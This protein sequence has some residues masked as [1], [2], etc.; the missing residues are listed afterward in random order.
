MIRD[1]D[2]TPTRTFA[3]YDFVFSKHDSHI[4]MKFCREIIPPDIHVFILALR[5]RIFLS[6]V[7]LMTAPSII[8]PPNDPIRGFAMIF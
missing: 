5:L 3:M 7:L 1:D 4:A 2:A 6:L 8:T